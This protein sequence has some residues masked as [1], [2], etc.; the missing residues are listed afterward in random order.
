[1]KKRIY[2]INCVFEFGLY[3]Y[4]YIEVLKLDE[5]KPAAAAL[6]DHSGQ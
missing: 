1:M 4:D 5:T 3:D 2:V 6:F